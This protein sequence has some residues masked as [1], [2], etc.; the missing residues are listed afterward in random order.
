MW[1]YFFDECLFEEYFINKPQRTEI[2]ESKSKAKFIFLE[3]NEDVK[4][5]KRQGILLY[6]IWGIA[7]G[8]F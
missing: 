4:G 7:Q 1:L 6:W 2:G 8:I 5:S 3:K